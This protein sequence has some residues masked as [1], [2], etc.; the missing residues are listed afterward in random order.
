MNATRTFPVGVKSV[1]AARKFACE[2]LAQ[3][4]RETLEAVELMVSELA[5]NCVKHAG[6]EFTVTIA[7]APAQLRIEVYDDG[8]GTPVMASPAPTDP[9]GRGLRIVDLLASRWGT[10][11]TRKGKRVWFE[12]ATDGV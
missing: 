4:S 9:T 11:V 8:H 10:D 5:T 6:S 12:L 3:L 7:L 2:S 1:P